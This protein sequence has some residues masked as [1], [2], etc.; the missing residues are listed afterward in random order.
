MT[1]DPP[2]AEHN[3]KPAPPQADRKTGKLP[4]YNVIL[5]NDDHNDMQYV[6]LT[7]LALTPL[8]EFQAIRRMAEAHKHGQTRLLTTHKE[9]A[10]LYQDQFKSKGLT[11]TIKP[12]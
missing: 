5:H 7:I 3:V 12:A 2:T 9:H 10:E 4:P 6:V 8:K 11:V 1:Q